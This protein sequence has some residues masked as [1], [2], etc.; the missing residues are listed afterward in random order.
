MTI[1]R[2]WEVTVVAGGDRALCDDELRALGEA[3]GELGGRPIGAGQAG[4]GVQLAV[5]AATREEALTI[6]RGLLADSARRAGLPEW[7]VTRAVALAEGE[8]PHAWPA[9]TPPPR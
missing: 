4:Y 2:R 9:P 1:V 6:A 3:V 5:A 7:P 8:A